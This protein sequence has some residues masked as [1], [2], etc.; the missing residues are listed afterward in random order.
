[1]QEKSEIKITLLRIP[2]YSPIG[3]EKKK[4]TRSK[5]KVGKKEV[6]R[7]TPIRYP[8]EKKKG[9]WIQK[10]FGHCN[11]KAPLR[12]SG[13]LPTGKKKAREAVFKK[14]RGKFPSTEQKF[15]LPLNTYEYKSI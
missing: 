1:M 9:I 12:T 13:P 7:K 3:I 4:K 11:F 14:N 5:R 8:A 2:V 15:D 6:R 10:P